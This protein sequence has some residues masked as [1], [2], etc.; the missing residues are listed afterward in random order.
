M[1]NTADAGIYRNA[2]KQKKRN[3]RKFSST[4]ALILGALVTVEIMVMAAMLLN[5]DFHSA[6]RI[7]LVLGF[8][9]VYSGV[10]VMLTDK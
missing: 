3:R 10:V 1:T 5:L 6:D 7:A 9:V 8:M 2:G 4:M